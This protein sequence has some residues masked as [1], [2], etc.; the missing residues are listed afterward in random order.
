[1]R[2]YVKRLLF[3]PKRSSTVHSSDGRPRIDEN[4]H[5]YEV[6]LIC[7]VL[8]IALSTYYRAKDLSDNFDKRSLRSQHNDF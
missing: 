6:E 7:R 8:P 3:S 2:S 1:M 5:Q 4:K